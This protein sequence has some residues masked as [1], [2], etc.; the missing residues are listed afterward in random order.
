VVFVVKLLPLKP[1]PKLIDGC[2]SA[3]SD[4]NAQKQGVKQATRSGA[5][6]DER[7]MLAPDARSA[8]AVPPPPSLVG[9]VGNGRV[10]GEAGASNSS[11]PLLIG[12]IRL[13][14]TYISSPIV[15]GNDRR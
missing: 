7:H 5:R 1:A 11:V 13:L 12:G 15:F 8:A 4:E 9:R 3:S 10:C 6:H 14:R 2:A